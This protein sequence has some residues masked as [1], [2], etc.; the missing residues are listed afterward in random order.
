M[1][2]LS[3]PG[4]DT[5]RQADPTAAETART[6]GPQTP[7]RDRETPAQ[8]PPEDQTDGLQVALIMYWAA[9]GGG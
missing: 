2:F 5:E 3:P 1:N 6:P 9:H 8:T 7:V 4:P